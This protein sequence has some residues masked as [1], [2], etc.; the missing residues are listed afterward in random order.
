MS[1]RPEEFESF[2]TLAQIQ[3]PDH[4]R[5]LEAM[6]KDPKIDIGIKAIIAKARASAHPQMK[7]PDEK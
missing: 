2:Q 3:D 5:N 6:L 1:L 4:Q 7:N